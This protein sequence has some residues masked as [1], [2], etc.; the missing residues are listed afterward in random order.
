MFGNNGEL[1]AK[2]EESASD[3]R[4]DYYQLEIVPKAYTR[5]THVS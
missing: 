5:Q 1:S 4:D 3:H 2:C